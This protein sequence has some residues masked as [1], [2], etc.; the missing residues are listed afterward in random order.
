MIHECSAMMVLMYGHCVMTSVSL[1][2][3]CMGCVGSAIC[4]HDREKYSC[5]KCKELNPSGLPIP[6]PIVSSS[7]SSKPPVLDSSADTSSSSD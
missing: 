6:I 1:R 7:S 4:E 5:R 3:L 2:L